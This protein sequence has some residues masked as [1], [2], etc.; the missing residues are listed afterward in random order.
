MYLFKEIGLT[1]KAKQTGLVGFSDNIWKNKELNYFYTIRTSI[2]WSVEKVN[3][4]KGHI[5]SG[6]QSSSVTT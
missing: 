4:M 5:C 3:G 2:V 6:D 1:L